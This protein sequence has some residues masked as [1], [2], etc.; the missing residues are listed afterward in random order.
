MSFIWYQAY[1][2]NFS[3]LIRINVQLVRK[4][5]ALDPL[6]KEINNYEFNIFLTC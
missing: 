5:P 4:Q 2:C 6:L 3:V 1:I